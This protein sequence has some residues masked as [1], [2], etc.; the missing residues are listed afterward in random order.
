MINDNL[1]V[2]GVSEPTDSRHKNKN[3]ISGIHWKLFTFK[4][5][6]S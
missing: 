4:K 5:A 1:N 2:T 3:I 6:L